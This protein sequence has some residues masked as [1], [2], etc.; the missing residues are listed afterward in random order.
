MESSWFTYEFVCHIDLPHTPAY[1]NDVPRKSSRAAK[2]PKARAKNVRQAATRDDAKQQTRAA[3]VQAAL[4]L[5]AE[6][7]LDV[8]S[9]DAICDR[10]GY[11]RGAFYV[12]F[13]TREDILV[14]VMDQVGAVFHAS[15]FEGFTAD[16]AAAA[17]RPAG[18]NVRARRLHHVMRRFVDAVGSGAYPLM[19]TE[20]K[21]P[22]IRP[23]QLIDACARSAIVRDR[24][25]DLVQVSVGAIASL[26]QADQDDGEVRKD[27]DPQTVAS[28]ALALV[29][30]AQTMAD[31]GLP[32]DPAD[33][34]VAI[35]KMLATGAS[36]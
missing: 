29:I 18:E 6:Q 24:Y 8:P 27:V 30:G 21:G 20:G 19:A 7:G 9:L 28:M 4:E 36:R 10:A 33:L 17:S 16:A 35:E 1:V 3:L 5:F 15:L 34:A 31:L 14:A 12:H 22:L 2:A 26:V 11:T 23:H 13:K 32:L 25:R